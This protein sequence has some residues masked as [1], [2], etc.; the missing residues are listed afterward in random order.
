MG[1]SEVVDRLTT[2]RRRMS[3]SSR[4][5][6]LIHN[7][8][9]YSDLRWHNRL[10]PALSPGGLICALKSRRIL[11]GDQ[12]TIISARYRREQPRVVR[13]VARTAR[14]V[15][16]SA[17]VLFCLPI[18]LVAQAAAEYGLKSAGSAISSSSAPSIAGCKFDSNLLTCLTDSY[19]RTSTVVA[20]AA[21]MFLLRWLLVQ[22]GYR[23]R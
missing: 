15:R 23:T 21:G 14:L 7:I 19:P 17:S 13:N 2:W 11:G 10:N 22:S 6:A 5:R 18:K 3:R 16:V 8:G 9:V 1:L 4:A 12:V 20:V